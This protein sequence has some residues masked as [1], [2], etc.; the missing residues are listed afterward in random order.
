MDYHFVLQGILDIA[1]EMLVSGAEVSRV[2]TAIEKMCEGYG[3]TRINAFSITSN[4]QV[5]MEAPDGEIITQI[6]QVERYDANFQKLDALNTLSREVAA[7]QP[8]AIEIQRLLN[9]LMNQPDQHLFWQFLAPIFVAGGFAI[10]FGGTYMDAICSALMGIV[11]TI[12]RRLLRGFENNQI[13]THFIMSFVGGIVAISLVA[14]KL[15][16]HQGVIV[17]GGIMLLIPGVN[18]TNAIR[19]MLIGDIASGMIRM[20]DAVLIAG[21]IACGFT[22]ALFIGGL[23]L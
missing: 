22:A 19:D 12:V 11:I 20:V 2:E 14:I 21:A 23:I 16:V 17:V 5:T 9:D 3:A 4:I 13:V 10:F 8:D 18:M 6:R 1:E 7:H 15:G